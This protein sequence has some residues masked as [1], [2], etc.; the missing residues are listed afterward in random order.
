[1]DS[2]DIFIL[3]HVLAIKFK[4]TDALLRRPLAGNEEIESDEDSW[5]DDIALCSGKS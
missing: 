5:L 2:E 1:M 4:S 3:I